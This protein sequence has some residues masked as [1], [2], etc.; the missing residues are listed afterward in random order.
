MSSAKSQ[1]VE[2]PPVV[3]VLG[4]VD[5]GKSTLLDFIR[6]SNTV[7]KEAGGIT[8]K[9][10]AYEIERDLPAHAGHEGEKKRITFI[11]TPGHAAFQAIRRRGAS[12]ADI[13]ILVVAADDGVMAQTLEALQEIRDA[14]IPF[15]VAIN[16]IDKPNADVQ[17]T[18]SSLLEQN[19]FLEKYGGDVPWA[20]IAAKQGTGVD[21]LLDLV[22]LVAE[23]QELKGDASLPAEGYVIEAHRDQKRGMAATLI[24]KNGTLESGMFVLAGTAL[25]PVRI[26]ENYAGKTIREATFSSPVSLIGFDE[27]PEVGAS[28]K[29]FEKKREAENAQEAARAA[30]PRAHTTVAAGSAEDQQ[31]FLMPIIVR[32]DS[33]GSLDAILFELPKLTDEHSGINIVQS[34]IG[35]IS[36]NDIKTAIASSQAASVIGF[37]VGVDSVAATLADRDGIRVETFDIIYKMTERLAELL[38]ETRPKRSVEE[39]VGRAKVLKIFS[40]RKDEHVLG[41]SVHS[42]YLAK[43]GSVRVVRRTIPLGAG[44]IVNIQTNKQNVD[45]AQEGSEFG[46]QIEA[47]FEIAAGDMLECFTTHIE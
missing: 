10:A 37:N 4:H 36:E 17:R 25:S 41:G 22:L 8:Q 11:D 33:Q 20:A 42:G 23:V 44:K 24:V 26:M 47:H 13:A 46:A 28:F 7:A 19:V 29:T 27:L 16:K 40:N 2:R 3:A 12:V 43:G 30:K 14:K 15:V 39:I 35:T 31:R 1:V 32:A 9:I 21:E 18:I 38:K 5:H 6:K 34:G 45:R